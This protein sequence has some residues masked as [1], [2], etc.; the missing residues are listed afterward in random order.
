MVLERNTNTAI[1]LNMVRKKVT[2]ILGLVM[3]LS[4]SLLIFIFRKELIGLKSYGYLGLFLLNLLGSATIILP[5]PLFLTTFVVA[6]FYNP[7]F[8][9][10]VSSLGSAL[11]ELTG[12]LVGFTGQEIVEDKRIKKVEKWMQRYGLWVVFVLA[13]IPNPLFDL[14]GIVAG[15]SEIPVWKYLIVVWSGK[16]IK[17]MVIAYLGAGFLGA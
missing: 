17:F 15:A 11:G 3:A 9:G 16:L 6:S 1:I 7:F 12:Y 8:V 14:A 4:I 13:A 5:T 10:L 2:K